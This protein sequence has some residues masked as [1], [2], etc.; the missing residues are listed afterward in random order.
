[1]PKV[2]RNHSLGAETVKI[3]VIG[4]LGIVAVIIAAALV[5][6]HLNNKKNQG[7]Q[8]NPS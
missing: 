4:V 8:Q 1:M 5:I 2:R 3:T 6:R 7:L